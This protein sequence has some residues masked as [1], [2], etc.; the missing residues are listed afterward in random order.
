MN[1][2]KLK[3]ENNF[4]VILINKIKL[5]KFILQLNSYQ[6]ENKQFVKL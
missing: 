4:I 1:D 5:N 3:I 6:Y 2:N